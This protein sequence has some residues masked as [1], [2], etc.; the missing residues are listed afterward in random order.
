MKEITEEELD[1]LR[2]DAAIHAL[3]GI[4]ATFGMDVE[5]RKEV[6]CHKALVLGDEFIRKWQHRQKEKEEYRKSLRQGVS[7]SD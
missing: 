3:P 7:S 4:A 5:F 1:D 6:I 2:L